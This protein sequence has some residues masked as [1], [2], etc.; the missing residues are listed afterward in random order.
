[1]TD[2][3]TTRA[4]AGPAVGAAWQDAIATFEHAMR[5]E[6]D[7]ARGVLATTADVAATALAMTQLLTLLLPS[8]PAPDLARFIRTARNFTPPK[9]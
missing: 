3:D 8:V 2:D 5:G 6:L 9:F 1:M 7:Q 4:A